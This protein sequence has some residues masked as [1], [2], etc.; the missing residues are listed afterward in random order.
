MVFGRSSG[1]KNPALDDAVAK[2]A[3]EIVGTA[4][5]IVTALGKEFPSSLGSSAPVGLILDI[6]IFL[7]HFADRIIFG[8]LGPERRP[9]FIDPLVAQTIW[10][11]AA[12]MPRQPDRS[13]TADAADLSKFVELASRQY[14]ERVRILGQLQFP[15]PPSEATK[16]HLF[17]R[18]AELISEDWFSS[19]EQAKAHILLSAALADVSGDFMKSLGNTLG[20]LRNR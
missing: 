12:I 13:A 17:W 10:S 11:V 20:A 19:E 14:D 9:A 7:L 8:S 3:A 15:S 1:K 2:T 5:A 6:S 16:N 4:K 18:A